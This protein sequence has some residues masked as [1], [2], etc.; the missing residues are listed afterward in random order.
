MWMYATVLLYTL[1]YVCTASYAIALSGALHPTVVY[2]YVLQHECL[3][4]AQ[5]LYGLTLYL[6]SRYYG[7]IHEV[8]DMCVVLLRCMYTQHV[9][10]LL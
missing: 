3:R 6:T 4:T 2:Y 9:G 10:V 1:H 7:W 8:Y 5:Y